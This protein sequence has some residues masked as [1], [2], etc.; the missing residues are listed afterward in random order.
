MTTGSVLIA[1]PD[2]IVAKSLEQWL[3][4]HGF[5]ISAIVSSGE[6]AIREAEN[7]RPDLVLIDTRLKGNKTSLTVARELRAL[8]KIP[9]VQLATFPEEFSREEQDC[10]DFFGYLVKP[11]SA[12]DLLLAVEMT[13]SHHRSERKVRE[14]LEWLAALVRSISDAMVTTDME[15]EVTSMNPAAERATGWRFA[16]V[17]NKP[18]ESVLTSVEGKFCFTTCIALAINSLATGTANLSRD[19]NLITRSGAEIPI[20]WNVSILQDGKGGSIGLVIIFREATDRR[21]AEFALCGNNNPCRSDL[22]AW[23][24]PVP[25]RDPV[26]NKDE[27]VLQGPAAGS[28]K[29]GDF[30]DNQ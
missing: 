1:E 10:T 9:S 15:G 25:G 5:S 30:H 2:S 7:R 12:K 24:S 26:V 18:L 8:L 29:Q 4:S 28:R 22:P 16:E 23:R 6:E 17:K 27:G 14:N 20:E 21:R 13:L 19:I 3:S 11:F